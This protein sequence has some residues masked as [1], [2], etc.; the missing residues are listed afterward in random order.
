MAERECKLLGDAGDTD[1]HKQ[2][3]AALMEMRAGFHNLT[4]QGHDA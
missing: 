2:D 3:D 4:W 1:I